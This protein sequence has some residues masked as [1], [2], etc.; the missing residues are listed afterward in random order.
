MG[1][2]VARNTEKDNW[3]QDNKDADYSKQNST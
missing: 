2:V 3:M 1:Y